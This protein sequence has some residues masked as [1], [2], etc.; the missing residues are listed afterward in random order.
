MN[1][2]FLDLKQQY[3]NLKSEIE[4]EILKVME[5]CAYIGGS[6]VQNF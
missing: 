4:P 3:Q 6:Y 2:P 1:V 5:S